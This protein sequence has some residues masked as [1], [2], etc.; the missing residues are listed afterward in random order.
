MMNF[1]KKKALILLSYIVASLS[2]NAQDD[3]SLS[4]GAWNSNLLVWGL[5][6]GVPGAA[7]NVLI[8]NPHNITVENNQSCNNLSIEGTLTIDGGDL[9]INS[10]LELETGGTID[11]QNGITLINGNFNFNGILNITS[12][13]T[14]Y[15]EL[16]GEL[17]K[18]GEAK[19]MV[20]DGSVR[21][22]RGI[23]VYINEI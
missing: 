23:K 8:N 13:P 17:Q 14:N 10:D 12:S 21:I 4:T 18:D 7:D 22:Y 5:I 1:I 11:I 16:N 6:T 20:I 3:S 2:M 19:W 9:A 15:V